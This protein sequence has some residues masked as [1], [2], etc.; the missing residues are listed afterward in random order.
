MRSESLQPVLLPLVLSMLERVPPKHFASQ[1]LPAL[2]PVLESA[3]G[4]MLAALV[5]GSDVL[6]RVMSGWVWVAHGG[7]W[8]T[9][10]MSRLRV[11]TD[12]LWQG[13]VVMLGSAGW[14][15]SSSWMW[16]SGSLL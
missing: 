13:R 16:S 6:A 10:R 11:S 8:P 1:L 15:W 3:N 7:L 12:S 2:V 9:R 5:K 4:E 14:M